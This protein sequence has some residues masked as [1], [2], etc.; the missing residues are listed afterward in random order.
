MVDLVKL[1]VAR[2]LIDRV[3]RRG[4][5]GL[6]P[7][8]APMSLVYARVR[9]EHDHPTVPVPVGNEDFVRPR[10]QCH[11]GGLTQT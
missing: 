3:L 2:T 4:I 9:I 1:G 6:V 7:V 8:G 5:V 10:I 11:I